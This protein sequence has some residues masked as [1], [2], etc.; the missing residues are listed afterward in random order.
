MSDADRTRYARGYLAGLVTAANAFVGCNGIHD[1]QHPPHPMLGL[2][3]S[4]L[5]AI[6]EDG[7]ET[8]LADLPA[9]VLALYHDMADAAEAGHDQG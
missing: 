9:D 8:V 5:F 3:G 6:S 4:V 7:T 1:E 2:N